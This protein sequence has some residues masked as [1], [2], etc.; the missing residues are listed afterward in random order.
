[1]KRSRVV[2][3]FLFA[4]FPIVFLYKSGIASSA[5]VVI[6]FS[7]GSFYDVVVDQSGCYVLFPIREFRNDNPVPPKESQ[8]YQDQRSYIEAEK[9]LYLNQLI[10]ITKKVKELIDDILLK[11]PEPPIIILQSDHDPRIYPWKNNMKACMRIL[12]AYHLPHIKSVLYESVT[13]VNTFRINFNQYFG[14]NFEFLDDESYYSDS[15]Q[16]YN[17]INVTEKVRYN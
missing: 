8:K 9:Q 12:N 10:F 11:S 13:P 16:P 17:F 2:H 4:V 6:F 1:M 14:T 5:L 3:P 15:I 7:Y